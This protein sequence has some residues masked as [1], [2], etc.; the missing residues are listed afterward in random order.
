[1]AKAKYYANLI[2][3]VA[4]ILATAIVVEAARADTVTTSFE[5][6]ATGTFS[7]GTSPISATFTGGNA[8][9]VGNFQ[10]YH[11]GRYSWHVSAG[12]I[13]TITFESPA[14]SVDLWYR[15]TPGGAGEVRAIDTGGAVIGTGTV[16]STFQ[17]FVVTRGAGNTLIASVEFENTG[18]ADIVMDDVR[19]SAT[20][21]DNDGD[22]IPDSSDNCPAIAN[23][24]QTDTDG[25]GLGDVCDLDDDGDGIP[26][27]YED[28]N[29]LDPLNAADATL[30]LD[31][32]GLTN[33][34]E[35][36]LG[37]AA[38]NPDTDG[39]GIDDKSEVD[40]GRNPTVN[41]AAVIQIINSILLD[42]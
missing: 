29:G 16:T 31:A 1:M 11:T 25:D 22:G 38:N 19:F 15:N 35:F 18:T 5:G 34:E 24:T 2:I 13:A 7:I 30:D 3:M 14:S 9:T 10:Y 36:Q 12:S 17:N 40:I 33:L 21:S 39:D 23:P 32:D 42:E 27:T 6:F 4:M 20:I 8:Q 28:T 41:E 37:T 26:D